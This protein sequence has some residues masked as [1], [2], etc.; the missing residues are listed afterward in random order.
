MRSRL[1]SATLLC[2]FALCGTALADDPPGARPR[3][4]KGGLSEEDDD[5]LDGALDAGKAKSAAVPG[6]AAPGT[7]A[8]QTAKIEEPPA[9]LKAKIDA[10]VAE[11][12]ARSD[13]TGDELFEELTRMGASSGEVERRLKEAQERNKSLSKQIE[14]LNR[15]LS[16]GDEARVGSGYGTRV[17]VAPTGNSPLADYRVR[18]SIRDGLDERFDPNRPLPPDPRGQEQ[19]KWWQRLLVT[20]A[21][22]ISEGLK[23]LAEARTNSLKAEADA[24]ALSTDARYRP[25]VDASVRRAV[26]SSTLGR[27][28]SRT[29]DSR[30]DD[31][32]FRK[33]AAATPVKP[34]Q[35]A[36]ARYDNTQIP[37]NASVKVELLPRVRDPIT[38]REKPVVNLTLGDAPLTKR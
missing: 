37:D 12:A 38:G 14:E 26:S 2:S 3:V 30:L 20:L 33:P 32:D 28:A 15:R 18:S 19:L 16:Q 11:L 29:R 5:L 9:Q 36:A 8:A 25:Y 24:L 27:N 4:G 21:E 6:S 10:R 22:G 17:E 7:A 13:A 23:T 1:L 31:L 34:T 35:P